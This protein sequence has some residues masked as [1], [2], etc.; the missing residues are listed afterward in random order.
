MKNWSDPN[1]KPLV[2]P[3]LFQE[4]GAN[5]RAP[6]VFFEGRSPHGHNGVQGYV[7]GGADESAFDPGFAGDDAFAQGDD[8]GF[9]S[10]ESDATAF[11]PIVPAEVLAPPPPPPVLEPEEDPRVIDALASLDES[12]RGLMSARQDA[13]T[14]SEHDVIR[15]AVALAQRIVAAE[16]KLRPELLLAAAREGITVL[17]ESDRYVVRVAP[18]PSEAHLAAFQSELV[19]KYPRSEVVV[20]A[21]LAPFTCVVESEHGRVDESTSARMA[22]VLEGAGLTKVMTGA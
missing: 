3:V 21:R 22:A 16:L 7:H 20:D 6:S 2:K 1:Q 15:L 8:G 5:D 12:L 11:D 9:D 19:S 18:G 10:Y 17:S 13:L 14:A 4:V